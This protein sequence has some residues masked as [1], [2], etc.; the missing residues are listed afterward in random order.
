MKKLVCVL[1]AVLTFMATAFA[2]TYHVYRGL[3]SSD[4]VYTI[5]DGHIYRG[6]SSSDRAYTIRD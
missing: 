2:K 4:I 1:I 6:L 5:R 3:S